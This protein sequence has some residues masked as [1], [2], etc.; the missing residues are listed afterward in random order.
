MGFRK[1]FVGRSGRCVFAVRRGEWRSGA[2]SCAGAG[3]ELTCPRGVRIFR[4]GPGSVMN[5][6]SRMSPPHPRHAKGKS[7]PTRAISFALGNPGCVVRAWLFMSVAAAFRGI[8]TDRMPT[9]RGIAPLADIPFWR[10]R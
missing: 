1:M 3:G 8:S 6:M 5:A 2:E 9:G 10:V 4:I 7:S